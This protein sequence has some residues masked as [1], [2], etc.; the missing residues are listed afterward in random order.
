MDAKARRT[1]SN[2]STVSII[3]VRGTLAASYIFSAVVSLILRPA[4][5]VVDHYI[6]A[7]D[8]ACRKDP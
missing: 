2:T 1:S 8:I 6:H 4:T 7:Y 5:F 3:Q